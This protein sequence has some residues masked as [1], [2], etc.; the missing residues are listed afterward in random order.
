MFLNFSEELECPQCPKLPLLRCQNFLRF[1]LPFRSVGFCL[2]ALGPSGRGSR[3]ATPLH[4]AAVYGHVSAVARL[5]EAK[6][7]VDV[8]DNDGRGLGTKGL[9]RE[10]LL[11]AMGSLREE[12][13]EMLIRFKVLVDLCFHFLGKVSVKTCAP[14]FCCGLCGHDISRLCPLSTLSC[15]FC[16]PTLG[17]DF[18]PE[19]GEST[20]LMW[21]LPFCRYDNLNVSFSISIA[22]SAIFGLDTRNKTH[23]FVVFHP[24]AIY[25]YFH[26]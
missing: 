12:V 21:H 16:G 3:G 19:F 26:W 9:G 15:F 13:D 11:E 6:A 24:Q 17:S 23:N 1:F 2:R 10:N 20:T 25:F 5:I 14:P 22:S 18:A 4:L 7:A 8:Q